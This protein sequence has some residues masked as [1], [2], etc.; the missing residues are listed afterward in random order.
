MTLAQ[1]TYVHGREPAKFPD[2]AERA[3]L[4][5]EKR[6]DPTLRQR[7]TSLLGLRGGSRV[8]TRSGGGIAAV[9]Y[10]RSWAPLPETAD[11]LCDVAHDLNIIRESG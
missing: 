3:K 2:D 8:M 11:E 10:L 5:R 1:G 7:V 4:A 6:C 9:A